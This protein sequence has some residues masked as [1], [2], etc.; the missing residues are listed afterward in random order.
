MEGF[1]G[2]ILSKTAKHARIDPTNL[3]PPQAEATYPAS[4]VQKRFINMIK[5]PY[6]RPP[7]PLT[8]LSQAPLFLSGPT[9][10]SPPINALQV[11][12][13]NRPQ[14]TTRRRTC[15]HLGNWW[16]RAHRRSICSST[17]NIERNLQKSNVDD[18]QLKERVLK[19]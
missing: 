12:V 2:E 13:P 18:W 9:T 5:I 10:H 16:S 14:C 8:P 7:S 17:C 4:E 15:H 11:T 3:D 6:P 1:S 19:A